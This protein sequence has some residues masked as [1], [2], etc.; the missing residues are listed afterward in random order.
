[1]P[2]AFSAKPREGLNVAVKRDLSHVAKDKTMAP[3]AMDV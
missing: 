2:R 3:T 1:M